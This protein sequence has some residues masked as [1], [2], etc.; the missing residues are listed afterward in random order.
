MIKEKKIFHYLI[1]A[2]FSLFIS[3]SDE[4]FARWC[5]VCVQ[6]R[7]GFKSLQ[8]CLR[9]SRKICLK[10]FYFCLWWITIEIFFLHDFLAGDFILGFGVLCQGGS[11]YFR[12]ISRHFLRTSRFVMSRHFFDNKI[13]NFFFHSICVLSVYIE[14]RV[15]M[16]KPPPL[17]SE[18]PHHKSF[19]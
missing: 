16:I 4:Y 10:I 19:I 6:S 11:R 18:N 13:A 14:F 7:R 12:E 2:I 8:S 15:W 5:R 3:F 1:F 17:S 9:L